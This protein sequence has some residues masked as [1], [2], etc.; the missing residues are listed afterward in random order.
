MDGSETFTVEKPPR[1]GA[2]AI[3]HG[4]YYL[5]SDT[6]RFHVVVTDATS[7]TVV[8]APAPINTL[9]TQAHLAGARLSLV[10]GPILAERFGYAKPGLGSG[11]NRE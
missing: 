10:I 6:L 5:D 9:Y 7:G 11:S 8:G 4:S 3:V 2:L 1:L